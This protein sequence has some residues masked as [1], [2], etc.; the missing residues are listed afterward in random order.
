MPKN[1]LLQIV[2]DVLSEGDFDTVSTWDETIESTQIGNM[3]KTVFFE[4]HANGLVKSHDVLKNPDA[5]TGAT[6]LKIPTDVTEVYWLR[7]DSQNKDL[8]FLQ[9]TNFIAKLDTGGTGVVD[10]GDGGLTLPFNL[11]TAPTY[12]TSFDDEYIAFDTADTSITNTDIFMYCQSEP[13]FTLAD[14]TVPDLPTD[15]GAYFLAEVKSR[16]MVALNQEV[17]PKVEM[18]ARELKANA[19]R[20][21]F[22]S[23]GTIRTPKFGRNTQSSRRN[24]R[25]ST[26]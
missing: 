5:A 4:L 20:R 12:W 6:Y 23:E 25:F 26:R 16:S 15:M 8:V 11:T 22:V 3:A 18:T 17:N 7:D 14:A 21:N 1:T 24:S 19:S 9:P 2:Q 10:P 13:T